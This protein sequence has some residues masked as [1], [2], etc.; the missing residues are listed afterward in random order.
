MHPIYPADSGLSQS[1]ANYREQVKAQEEQIL[2]QSKT[3][4]NLKLDIDQ[5]QK[6]RDAL[7]T[8]LDVEKRTSQGRIDQILHLNEEV[9]TTLDEKTKLQERIAFLEQELKKLEEGMDDPHNYY[10][11]EMQRVSLL[12]WNNSPG[13]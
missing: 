4:E 10:K 1:L 11:V 2:N 13:Y 8:S 9:I 5:L 12:S 3:I 7:Q 6:E